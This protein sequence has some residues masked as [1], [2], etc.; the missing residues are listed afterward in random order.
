MKLMKLR[1]KEDSWRNQLQSDLKAGV[2][3]PMFP[4]D[5]SDAMKYKELKEALV[6]DANYTHEELIERA[7]QLVDETRR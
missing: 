3:R 4:D 6:G 7:L 1:K 2:N 5:N